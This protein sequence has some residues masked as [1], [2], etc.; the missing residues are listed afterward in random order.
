VL[1]QNAAVTIAQRSANGRERAV[2]LS[3]TVMFER[4][5]RRSQAAGW[6]VCCW[7]ACNSVLPEAQLQP[8]SSRCFLRLTRE[9]LFVAASTFVAGAWLTSRWMRAITYSGG[10]VLYT[11]AL[12]SAARLGA[13][14]TSS[15]GVGRAS[16]GGDSS[17]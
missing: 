7:A 15:C 4:G 8:G 12:I 13:T 11:G 3:L 10:T 9:L 14:S 1:L 17:V 2:S 6:R 5:A 16:C